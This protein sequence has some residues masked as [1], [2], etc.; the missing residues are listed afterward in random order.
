MQ[1]F[2]WWSW[3]QGREAVVRQE[4]DIVQQISSFV[5][6]TCQTFGQSITRAVCRSNGLLL[7]WNKGSFAGLENNFGSSKLATIV[8]S[9]LWAIDYIEQVGAS[10][11]DWLV[12]FYG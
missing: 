2:L 10:I 1:A 7:S 11:I 8:K 6:F 4:G 12:Q 5:S 9:H 3:K